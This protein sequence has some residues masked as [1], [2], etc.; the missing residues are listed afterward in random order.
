[1]FLTDETKKQE[2]KEDTVAPVEKEETGAEPE[3]QEVQSET[4]DKEKEAKKPKEEP[5]EQTEDSKL[6]ELEKQIEALTT[7]LEAQKDSE[8][9][10]DPVVEEEKTVDLEKD[11]KVEQYEKAL[12]SVVEE[13][14]AAIPDN[15]KALMPDN[16]SAVDKLAWVE[17]AAKAVPEKP[18]EE[19]KEPVVAIGKPT[20][21]QTEIAVDKKLSPMEKFQVAFGDIFGNEK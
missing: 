12:N 8:A 15:I 16:L 13:K 21:V 7:A 3:K 18:V 9:K 11:S 1:M 14:L 20:P 2:V 4:P 17:K 6:K 19:K 5:K 10:D